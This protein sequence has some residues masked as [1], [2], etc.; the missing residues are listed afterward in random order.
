MSEESKSLGERILYWFEL[1]DPENNEA[2]NVWRDFHL[3]DNE[4]V[5]IQSRL[6][7]YESPNVPRIYVDHKVIGQ[8]MEMGRPEER[9]YKENVDSGDFRAYLDWREDLPGDQG[10]YRIRVQI[11]TKIAPSGEN[12]FAMVQYRVDTELKYDTP[13]GITFLPRILSRPLNRFFKWAY[14]RFIAEEMIDRD[15]EFAL[16][17]TREYFQYLRKYHGEEPSQ[18]KSREAQF[19]P[20]PEEGIFFQ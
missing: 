12:D 4:W 10:E 5:E 13:Q 8:N 15:G 6:E 18:S 16:E 7:W 19:T 3:F 20:L 2:D 17:K 11:R 9:Y 1:P 14:M